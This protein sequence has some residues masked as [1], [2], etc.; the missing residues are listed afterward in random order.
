MQAHVVIIGAGPA[1]LTAAYL[2]SKEGIAVTVLEADPTYVG[3]IARTVTYHD[4]YFDIGGHRFFSKSDEV[5]ALWT[6][7]LPNDMIDRPRSSRIFY[8]NQFFCYPLKA[9]DALKKMGIVESMLCVA[10]Y[11]K[12]QLFPIKQPISFADWVTNRFGKRLYSIFFKTYTEKVWGMPCEQISADWAAQRIKGLSL[13][14][15]I[16]NALTTGNNKSQIKTLIDKFR[17]PRKGPGMLWE[18]CAEKIIAQGGVINMGCD[19]HRCEYSMQNQLWDIYYRQVNG[20]LAKV[21]AT[22][23]ISSAPLRDLVTHYL[24]P[25]ASPPVLEAANQLKYRDFLIVVLIVKDRNMFNDNWIYIHDSNVDVA[26]IQNFKSWS[27]DMVPIDGVNCYGMEYFCFNGDKLWDAPDDILLTKARAE[28]AKLG[29][30]KSEDI[31]DGCVVRQSKAYPVYDKNY[32]LNVDIIR[33]ELEAKFPTLYVVGR[34]GM[35]KY[36]NQDHAMMTALLTVKNILAGK[37][38]YDVWQVNQDAEYHEE[39]R[40]SGASGLRAV[41]ERL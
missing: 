15:A 26:R 36:N 21:S 28:I 24:R 2:L 27:P 10:S 25:F 40:S 31:I 17:Y 12:S 35:H 1:G 6:E 37:R 7:M 23:L 30:A 3:G 5:E 34:N 41:P 9:F 20:E 33:Q 29:L 39:G 19:V 14:S 11:L 13:F 38:D 16:K 4:C 22:H 8:R 32:S 18:A